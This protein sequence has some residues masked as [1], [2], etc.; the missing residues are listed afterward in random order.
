MLGLEGM[1]MVQTRVRVRGQDRKAHLCRR[2]GCKGAPVTRPPRCSLPGRGEY[3]GAKQGE[4]G[5]CRCESMGT[6]GTMGPSRLRG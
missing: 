4:W 2:A 6:T 1:A 3:G 5:L